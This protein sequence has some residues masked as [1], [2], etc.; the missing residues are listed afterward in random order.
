MPTAA[1]RITDTIAWHP[2]RL[3]MPGTSPMEVLSA[4]I[5]D[6]TKVL[7]FVADNSQ[8]I[9]HRKQIDTVVITSKS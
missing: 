1:I 3:Q 8:I 7:K 2:E 6:L 4:A 5:S 9:A